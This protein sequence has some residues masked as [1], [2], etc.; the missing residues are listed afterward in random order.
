HYHNCMMDDLARGTGDFLP[1]MSSEHSEEFEWV[2]GFG[3]RGPGWYK[4]RPQPQ[5]AETIFL[6]PL[7]GK[8]GTPPAMRGRFHA[9][10]REDLFAR[11]VDA[12]IVAGYGQQTFREVFGY[13][14]DKGIPVAL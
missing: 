12:V 2:A 11:Q 9:D 13:C 5:V 14:R 1:G 7:P 3:Y 4:D 8:E 10:W 6:R